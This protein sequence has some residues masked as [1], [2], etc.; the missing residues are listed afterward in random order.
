MSKNQTQKL[1]EEKASKIKVRIPRKKK[2][3]LGKGGTRGG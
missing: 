3:K 1:E 2:I